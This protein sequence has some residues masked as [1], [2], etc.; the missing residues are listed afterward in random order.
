MILNWITGIFIVVWTVVGIAYYVHPVVWF[1]VF[2]LVVGL[3]AF[4]TVMRWKQKSDNR[5]DSWDGVISWVKS[6]VLK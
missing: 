5:G 4:L 1:A 6:K 2:W 3:W